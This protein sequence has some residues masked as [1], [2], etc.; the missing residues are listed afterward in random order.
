MKLSKKTVIGDHSIVLQKRSEFI[1]RALTDMDCY[2]LRKNKLYEIFDKYKD[3]GNKMKSK[4]VSKYQT[5]IREPVI[6]HKEQLIKKHNRMN[7]NA[8]SSSRKKYSN[9]NLI[10]N[11]SGVSGS[12]SVSINNSMNN[13]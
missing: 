11:S 8:A 2:G 9:N 4:I 5:L 10:N 3:L 1:Y 13:S 6:N 12:N 7:N